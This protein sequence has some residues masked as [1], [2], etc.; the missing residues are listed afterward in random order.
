M[1]PKR[2]LRSFYEPGLVDPTVSRIMSHNRGKDTGPELQLR[3][4]LSGMGVRFR[5]HPKDVPGRPDIIHRGSKVAVFVDGCF[6][7]GCPRHFRPPKTRTAYW[8]EK[9]R[10]NKATR[11]RVLRELRPAWDVLEFYECELRED[12]E[13]CARKVARSVN[14]RAP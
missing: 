3:A 8:T 11:R 13:G 12:L 1:K 7:H 5:Y 6:W 14:N 4:A 9:I 10:R 2:T